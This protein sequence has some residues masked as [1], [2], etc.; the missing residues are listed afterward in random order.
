MRDIAVRLVLCDLLE[1]VADL[2]SE[3]RTDPGLHGIRQ[4]DGSRE[5]IAIAS[6]NVVELLALLY[7]SVDG[8]AQFDHEVVL[9]LKNLG[10]AWSTMTGQHMDRLQFHGVLHH[11]GPVSDIPV[12][13]VIIR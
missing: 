13:G 1:G 11:V 2:G 6:N 5:P 10:S 4:G 8:L 9:A 3:R 7:S 12:S